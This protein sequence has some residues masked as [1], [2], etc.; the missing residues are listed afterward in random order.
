MEKATDEEV[1]LTL[2]DEKNTKNTKIETYLLGLQ[3]HLK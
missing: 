2:N 3:F 1:R